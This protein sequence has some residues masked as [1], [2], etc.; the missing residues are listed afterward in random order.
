MPGLSFSFGIVAINKVPVATAIVNRKMDLIVFFIID[1]FYFFAWQSNKKK[2]LFLST[3][4]NLK[5]QVAII[6]VG[7]QKSTNEKNIY[8]T[9]RGAN[10]LSF[11]STN[12]LKGI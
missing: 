11:A 1:V 5:K 4:K 10:S 3:I 2:K 9:I 7:N 8:T 12:W 6:F